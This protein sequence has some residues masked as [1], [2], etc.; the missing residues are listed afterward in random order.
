[1]QSLLNKLNETQNNLDQLRKMITELFENDQQTPLNGELP[2]VSIT[3]VRTMPDLTKVR[4][5]YLTYVKSFWMGQAARRKPVDETIDF[6]THNIVNRAFDELSPGEQKFMSVITN[7]YNEW[8]RR[9]NTLRT[10]AGN[11]HAT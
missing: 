8:A 1:M 5:T 9:Q 2:V 10:I 3:E 6:L 4:E 7:T 11:H